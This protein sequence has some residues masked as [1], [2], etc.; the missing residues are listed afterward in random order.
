M[1]CLRTCTGRYALNNER[2][3]LILMYDAF[4]EFDL[5]IDNFEGV[6]RRDMI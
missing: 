3:H 6:R 4:Y 1:L 2:D 5:T